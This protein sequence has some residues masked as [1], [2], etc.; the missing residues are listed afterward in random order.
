MA[1][2]TE[3]RVDATR[4]ALR[5]YLRRARDTPA[6]LQADR[7]VWAELTLAYSTAFDEWVSECEEWA[8]AHPELSAAFE[9]LEGGQADDDHPTARKD[10]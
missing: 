2:T 4:Q 9:E 5:D 6:T 1:Q 3:E 7:Q 8:S 10:G